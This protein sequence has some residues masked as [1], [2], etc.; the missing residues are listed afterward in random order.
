MK[1]TLTSLLILLTSLV[2]GQTEV[3]IRMQLDEQTDVQL[4]DRLRQALQRSDIQI[5]GISTIIL[6]SKLSPGKSGEIEG[7]AN[8]QILAYDLLLEARLAGTQQLFHTSV[9]ALQGSGS[10]KYEAH[11][12]AIR[13]LGF[14]NRTWQRAIEQ[15]KIDYIKTLHENCGSLLTEAEQLQERQ[16]LLTALA[17][18][19]G[20]PLDAPCYAQ[21]REYRERYYQSYQETYCQNHLEQARRQLALELPKAALAEIAKIDASAPCADEAKQLL[22]T[23][24]ATLKDQQS[25]KAQFLRQV[26]QNQVEVETARSK[27]ITGLLEGQ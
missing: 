9:V 6:S 21:A 13:Q 2:F 16:Q 23:A 26:Y 5:D 3:P 8:R 20:I 10:N 14:R 25:A 1:H 27:V 15:L 22:E 4:V 18:A 11:Q 19:D 17:L 12:A 7:I 24:A